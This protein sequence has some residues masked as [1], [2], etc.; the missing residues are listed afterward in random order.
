MIKYCPHEVHEVTL[1]YLGGI[2]LKRSDAQR[3]LSLDLVVDDQG[4]GAVMRR[5]SHHILS[6]IEAVLIE[7]LTIRWYIASARLHCFNPQVK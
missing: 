1:K 5:Q 6:L 7:I 3:W 2:I 4:V